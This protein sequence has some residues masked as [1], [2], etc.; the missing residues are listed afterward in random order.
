MFLAERNLDPGQECHQP[1][2]RAKVRH[3]TLKS[4]QVSMVCENSWS[5][6]IPREK[7]SVLRSA[8]FHQ[9]PSLKIPN[10]LE[11][12]LSSRVCSKALPVT[13]LEVSGSQ[14]QP[15]CHTPLTSL[16]VYTH[17]PSI[18][19]HVP[20]WSVI[21]FGE[22]LG[23]GSVPNETAATR[24]TSFST[25]YQ[26]FQPHTGEVPP[27]VALANGWHCAWQPWLPP[28][29]PSHFFYGGDPEGQGIL[30]SQLCWIS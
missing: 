26:P 1:G 14:Q 4:R 12:R 30:T 13:Y 10:S 24:V 25:T 9:S 17:L 16:A 8:K 20:P 5:T 22:S 7:G 19:S 27:S 3:Y 29:H 11:S 15:P 2:L 21:C 23:A 28:A 6:D 18:S